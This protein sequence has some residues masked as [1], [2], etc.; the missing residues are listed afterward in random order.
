MHLQ[1]PLA[2]AAQSH[3]G[4]KTLG[5]S[6][7]ALRHRKLRRRRLP[8]ASSAEGGA[9][10]LRQGARAR[11]PRVAASSGASCAACRCCRDRHDAAVAHFH[12]SR[13]RRRKLVA[14]IKR[15][16]P[17]EAFTT[18]P[19]ASSGSRCRPRP[20]PAPPRSA[21]PSRIHGGHATLIRAERRRACRGRSVPAAE[22][23]G[24][25][26]TRGLKPRSIPPAFSIP[27]AC[28]PTCELH[29]FEPSG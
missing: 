16:M 14:A 20:T 9:Q 26:L 29:P 5:K 12:A 21:A 28:T 6:V 7:T 10:G 13:R 11:P 23:G 27:A 1:A 17:A 15:Y 18:G 2:R 19:A 24:R 4:L 3:A 22:P 25:A 8:A